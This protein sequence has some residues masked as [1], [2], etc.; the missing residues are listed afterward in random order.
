MDAVVAKRLQSIEFGK[1]QQ[2]R[3][4]AVL[5]ILASRD[6]GPAYI[7][8]AEALANG[9]MTV[10]EVGKDGSVPELQVTNDG[11]VA[12]LL[13][14]GE[15][16]AGAKQNRVLN[17]SILLAANSKT[18][19]PVSCTEQGRWHGDPPALFDS[20]V[21]MSPALRARKVRSVTESLDAGRRY[22]SDQAEVWGG[23][24]ELSF[25]A[26]VPSATGAM[27][28]VFQARESDLETYLQA[29]VSVEQQVGL[30]VLVDGEVV[31]FDLLSRAEAYARLHGK[32][33]KSY[34][35]EALLSGGKGAG[36]PSLETAKAFVREVSAC[37]EKRHESVGKG[38]DCR[39]RGPKLVGSALV[40][41][42]A[43]VHTAFFRVDDGDGADRIASARR[44]SGYRV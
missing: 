14:D 10:T 26:R 28:D 31:G 9:Q 27:R 2:H 40:C 11:G 8:L 33:V 30:L 24:N 6:G 32:L 1:L 25:R 42:E 3:N 44:R 38:W 39:Y 29:F 21:V 41:D 15:E 19:I 4:M 12:V 16:L 43:V 17:T 34:A 35:M 23:V 7:T 20:R 22:R 18:I 5:P 37:E 36:Q 13:L